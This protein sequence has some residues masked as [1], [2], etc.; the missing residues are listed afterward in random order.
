[1]QFGILETYI[2]I[3]VTVQL[4]GNKTVYLATNDDMTETTDFTRKC[5]CRLKQLC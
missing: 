3:H 2:T 5:L 4:T 1:M